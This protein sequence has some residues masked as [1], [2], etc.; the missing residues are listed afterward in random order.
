MNPEPLV[1]IVDDIKRE[2]T[3]IEKTLKALNKETIFFDAK[4]DKRNPP[5]RPIETIEILFLDLYYSSPTFD[6][7]QVVQ[8]VKEIVPP[9]KK[10][11]LVIWSN[12]TENH[13]EEL[14][15]LLDELNLKPNFRE[16]WQKS[17]INDVILPQKI[18]SL[19]ERVSMVTQEVVY[20]EIVD[21]E[22]DGV[23]IN[24]RLSEEIPTFQVRKFDL[25]LLSNIE[26]ISIG[27]YVR[28]H[29]FSKPGAR[30][31]DVFEEK[32]DLSS[33][34]TGPDLFN[35]LEGSSFFIGS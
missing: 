11:A 6:A 3:A 27:V 25:E 31:I 12:D 16:E 17:E 33:R 24:C 13:T 35:G 1:A 8:W 30:L 18:S 29:I 4:P 7:E 15:L 21:I 23:L 9:N 2:T 34:F 14:L 20:G 19:I 5:E 28:I 10:Y 22:D 26:S 32:Q